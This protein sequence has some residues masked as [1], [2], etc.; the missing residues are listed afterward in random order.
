MKNR[1][2]FLLL[3]FVCLEWNAYAVI[4]IQ[5]IHITSSDGLANNTIRD[6]F[7]DKK[8]FIWISTTNGL[9]RY[10]G[11]SFITLLP[12]KDSPISLADYH[13]KK[14]DEDKNGFL[15]VLSTSNVFSCY[16]LRHN[17]FVDFTGCG[18]HDQAYAY[19]VE[20]ANDDNW[21]WDGQKGCRKISFE[22]EHF[23]S[24]TFQCENG[25]LPSN[26][27]NSLIED[28][29]G[30]V[31]ICTQEGL[32]KVTRNKIEVISDMHNFRAAFS[33]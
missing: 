6:I 30:N 27:V 1:I 5:S 9:S 3:F 20:T 19:R 21:L 33:Y 31:W 10:D 26:K 29:R 8:G 7:Q 16:D 15:W 23:S 28:S 14:I 22:N 11:H 24:V 13:V 4:D 32:V 18:E 25:K 12:E 17:C 2:F